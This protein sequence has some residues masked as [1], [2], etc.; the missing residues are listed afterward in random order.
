MSER[1][2]ARVIQVPVL[3]ENPFFLKLENRKNPVFLL[4][5][6]RGK[7]HVYI[8]SCLQW[9]LFDIQAFCYHFLCPSV[10][11]K[12]FD[13]WF[14]DHKQLL[15]FSFSSL[16][17]ELN[18]VQENLWLK[19]RF[20]FVAGETTLLQTYDTKAFCFQFL[21]LSIVFKFLLLNS[22]HN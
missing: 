4:P 16:V 19:D 3:P 14:M 13:S 22:N 6:I 15:Q 1:Y 20:W 21:V 12:S 11:V 9:L 7:M 8:L 17:T 18:F 10:C 5:M 2:S